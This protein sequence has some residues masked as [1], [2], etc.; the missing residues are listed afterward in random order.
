MN[1]LPSD[2][3]SHLY[4]SLF[5]LGSGSDIFTVVFFFPH[6]VYFLFLNFSPSKLFQVC[7]L[8]LAF[9]EYEDMYLTLWCKFWDIVDC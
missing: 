2:L 6:F 1:V 7:R 3:S 9:D 4:N 5:L 8:L